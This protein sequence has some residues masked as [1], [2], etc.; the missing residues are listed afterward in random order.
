M[1]Y[2][3]GSCVSL[4][5]KQSFS[6]LRI[7]RVRISIQ[8]FVWILLNDN[9]CYF[10]SILFK[11]VKDYKWEEW[12]KNDLK[13][14]ILIWGK[15]TTTQNHQ[16][17]FLGSCVSDI[18]SSVWFIDHPIKLEYLDLNLVM[19]A[20][21]PMQLSILIQINADMKEINTRLYL[22]H[23]SALKNTL[24]KRRPLFEKLQYFLLV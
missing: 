1:L 5:W 15:I 8:T 10:I 23:I 22:V 7:K 19:P 20:I 14:N 12:R 6:I 18:V 21:S 24:F 11:N 9:I 17:M 16:Y 3:P 13:R 2:K 4:N